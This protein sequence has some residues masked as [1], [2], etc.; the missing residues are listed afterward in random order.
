MVEIPHITPHPDLIQF[1]PV[2]SSVCL[3]RPIRNTVLI[4]E[5]ANP[6]ES[7]MI[8]NL[9]CLYLQKSPLQEISLYL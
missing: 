9:N 3:Q 8:I 1:I 6:E 5:Q 7:E 2:Q 4:A